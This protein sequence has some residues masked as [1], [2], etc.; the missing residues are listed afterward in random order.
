MS[1][2]ERDSKKNS[3]AAALAEG[4]SCAAWASANGVSE[5]TAQRWASDPEVREE[6]KLDRRGT[7]DQAVGRMSKRVAWATEQIAKLARTAR[8]AAGLKLATVTHRAAARCGR[9]ISSCF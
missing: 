4:Q 6:V 1:R 5:R 8:S 3:L 2:D 7:L 9:R